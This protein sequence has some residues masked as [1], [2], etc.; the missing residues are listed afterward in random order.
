MRSIISALLLAAGTAVSWGADLTKIDRTIHK[1][2]TYEGRPKYCLLVFGLEAKTR[3]W[4]VLDGETLYVD[5]NGNGDLTE[6]GERFAPQ[7]TDWQNPGQPRIFKYFFE[8]GDIA[9]ADQKTKFGPLWIL[10]QGT[11]KAVHENEGTIG[12]GGHRANKVP[13]SARTDAPIIHFAGPLTCCTFE[14][15]QLVLGQEPR[16]FDHKDSVNWLRVRVGTPCLGLGPKFLSFHN[17]DPSRDLEAQADIDFPCK[18]GLRRRVSY[19][20]SFTCCGPF[21]GPVQVP[22]DAV[23]GKAKVVVS[24]PDSQ[25]FRVAPATFEVPIVESRMKE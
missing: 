6:E 11:A 3:V 1:E 20:L 21:N 14:P 15:E 5:R 13:F 17:N 18:D 25:Q 9:A 4:L 22:D 10:F 7:K 12:V 24:F 23:S 8:V 16:H 19:K 2:P